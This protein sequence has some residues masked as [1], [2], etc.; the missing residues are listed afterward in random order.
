MAESGLWQRFAKP[1]S[2]K[3]SQVQILSSPPVKGVNMSNPCKECL[4]RPAC[5][6]VCPNKENYGVTLE[7]GLRNI[8]SSFQHFSGRGM[9]VPKNI[10]KQRTLYLEKL[11]DHRCEVQTIL[12][13]GGERLYREEHIPFREKHGT[14]T[15]YGKGKR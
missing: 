6:S 13:D 3:A 12:R 4:V 10:L 15:F 1:S 5:R 14:L 7:M 11:M 9:K 8:N 2:V